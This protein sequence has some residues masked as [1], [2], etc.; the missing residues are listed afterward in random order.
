MCVYNFWQ[1]LQFS[2]AY[3]YFNFTFKICKLYIIIEP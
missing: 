1:C 2:T 3:R